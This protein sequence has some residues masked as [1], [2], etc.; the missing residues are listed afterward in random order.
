MEK[1]NILIVI[2]GL[3][4]AFY[5]VISLGAGGKKKSL[6]SSKI[7]NY[8]AGV[9]ILIVLLTLIALIFWFFI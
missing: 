4:L 5:I 2:I 6:Q 8:R 3:F 1:I 9:N 7:K